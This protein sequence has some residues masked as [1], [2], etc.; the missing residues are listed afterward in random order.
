MKIQE[1]K[2]HI[3]KPIFSIIQWLEILLAIFIIFAVIVNIKDIILLVFKFFCSEGVETF[4]I[5]TSFLENVLLLV[6]GIELMETLISHSPNSIIEVILYA[7][8][9]KMLIHSSN[10]YELLAGAI[11]IAVLFGTKRYFL[12]DS[13]NSV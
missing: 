6:I 7:I 4:E 8:A 5:F 13:Q 9:R 12:P 10:I 1:L 2:T 11:A 3:T